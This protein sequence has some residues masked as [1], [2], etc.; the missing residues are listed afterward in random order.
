MLGTPGSSFLIRKGDLS[1]RSWLPWA[2]VTI[3]TDSVHICLFLF[4][5]LVLSLC[6]CRD[7]SKIYVVLFLKEN[8]LLPLDVETDLG[9][10]SVDDS[11]RCSGMASLGYQSLSPW[12][13]DFI[14]D[15]CSSSSCSL[16]PQASQGSDCLSVQYLHCV[17]AR[18]SKPFTWWSLGVVKLLHIILEVYPLIE[19]R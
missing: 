18:R 7:C 12:S 4:L 17:C 16:R 5:L 2:V 6:S 3:V 11:P 19:T 15:G 10:T 14:E 13:L 8:L 1:R 9:S